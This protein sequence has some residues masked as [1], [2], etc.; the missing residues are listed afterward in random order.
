MDA[1]GV[2]LAHYRTHS[3]AGVRVTCR[4]CKLHRDLPLESV[5]ERLEARGVGGERTGIVEL[6]QLVRSPCTRCGGRRFVTA[7]C[8]G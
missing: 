3:S 7:P 8:W 6:A 5:I 1:V 4:D 2:P